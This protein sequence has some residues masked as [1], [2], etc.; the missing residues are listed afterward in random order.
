MLYFLFGPD[1]YRSKKK[2]QDI[3]ERA[4]ELFVFDASEQRKNLFADFA[5][6]L[7]ANSLFGGKK[8]LVVE[9]LLN[10]GEKTDQECFLNIID[11]LK[12]ESCLIV[13]WEQKTDKRRKL[14][15]AL[16]K[17]ANKDNW[18]EFNLLEGKDL[19]NW[20]EEN[21]D[22]P[23][24]LASKLI[25]LLGNNLWRI[26]N[27]ISKIKAYFDYQE[28]DS[29]QAKEVLDALIKPNLEKDIFQ[30]VEALAKREKKQV[31]Q[32]LQEHLA[33]GDDQNYLFSM[34]IWQFEVLLKIKLGLTSD[35]HPF[36]IKK[37]RHLSK[38]YSREKLKET[39]NRLL[40]IDLWNKT[41]QIE[42]PATFFLLFSFLDRP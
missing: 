41:G 25:L 16:K 14:F 15:K 17:K 19:A 38:T 23:S 37:N 7:E 12:K 20:L 1:T 13:F 30:T 29:N 4:N 39:F 18:E 36:V 6:E 32:F 31:L 2:L 26:T 42:Q 33:G 28:L 24:E 5:K 9:N 35:L 27:E 34:F 22:I 10:Q 21:Q 11:D 40:K 3:K 8:V